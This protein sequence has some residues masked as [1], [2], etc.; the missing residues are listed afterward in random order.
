[1]R[2]SFCGLPFA[3]SVYHVRPLC[4]LHRFFFSAYCYALVFF[5]TCF[6][7]PWFLVVPNLL[8]VVFC[9][10]RI[11]FC[12]RFRLVAFCAYCFVICVALRASILDV[13]AWFDVHSPV[14]FIHI[15]TG[16]G[17]LAWGSSLL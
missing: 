9:F 16:N 2:F 5:L 11:A 1:M 12:F 15:S 3:A 8:F 6:W 13:V 17:A 14:G 10:A 4:S 7:V